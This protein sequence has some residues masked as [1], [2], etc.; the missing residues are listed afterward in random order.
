MRRENK[1]ESLPCHSVTY[2]KIVWPDA[3]ISATYKFVLVPADYPVDCMHELG[4]ALTVYR[5]MSGSN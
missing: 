4:P 5:T 3:I 1:A 2:T